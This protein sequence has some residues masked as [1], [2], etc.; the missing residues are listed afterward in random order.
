MGLHNDLDFIVFRNDKINVYHELKKEQ[1]KI[2][3]DEQIKNSSNQKEREII[4]QLIKSKRMLLKKSDELAIDWI[5]EYDDCDAP[6]PNVDKFIKNFLELRT[7][8]HIHAAKAERLEA[9]I[10]GGECSSIKNLA[11]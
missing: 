11:S 8:H 3:E 2:L 7:T 10:S 4:Q 5:G 6:N 1:N 9:Q